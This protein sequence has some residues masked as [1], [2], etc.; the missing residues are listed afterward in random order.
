MKQTKKKTGFEMAAITRRLR[1][2]LLDTDVDAFL[3]YDVLS[4]IAETDIRPGTRGYYYFWKARDIVH[5]DGV[6]FDTIERQ[7][8]QRISHDTCAR[9][10]SRELSPVKRQIRRRQ[11]KLSHISLAKVSQEGR[12]QYSLTQTQFTLLSWCCKHQ[13]VKKIEHVVATAKAEIPAL[14]LLK[15]IIA[16]KKEKPATNQEPATRARPVSHSAHRG[17]TRT[18]T[19][20]QF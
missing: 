11:K 6:F 9:G 15:K 17:N 4:R 12:E 3:S 20:V 19:A 8:V 13:T 18:A 16:G 14:K 1:D 5:R 7:G 2:Y 10:S